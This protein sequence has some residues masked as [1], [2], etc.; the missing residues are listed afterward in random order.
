MSKVR[1]EK[2]RRHVQAAGNSAADDVEDLVPASSAPKPLGASKP[3]TIEIN[4]F[5]G[6]SFS[7]PNASASSSAPPGKS[8]AIPSLLDQKSNTISLGGAATAASM[9]VTMEDALRALEGRV[10]APSAAPK[11]TSMDIRSVAA[12]AAPSASSSSSSSTATTTAAAAAASSS[13]SSNSGDLSH[14]PKHLATQ[15]ALK[16]AIAAAQVEKKAQKKARKQEK[17]QK[18]SSSVSSLFCLP[19]FPPSRF[20][21]ALTPFACAHLGLLMPGE[22][23]KFVTKKGLKHF[24]PVHTLQLTNFKTK[25]EQEQEAKRV[26]AE[27][28]AQLAAEPGF[29]SIG[30]LRDG[31]NAAT[32]PDASGKQPNTAHTRKQTAYVHRPP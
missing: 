11:V 13:S 4:A 12:A 6:F 27:R 9:G 28:A 16:K 1:R 18:F 17:R 8:K 26:K 5:R 31:L 29:G 24:D 15:V 10:S 21:S 23:S 25:E 19:P 3:A 20:A 7:L 2:T 14:L 32:A 22:S 30:A